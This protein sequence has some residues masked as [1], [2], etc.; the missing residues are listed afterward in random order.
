[1][2]K[3]KRN[4]NTGKDLAMYI[5]KTHLSFYKKRC[6]ILCVLILSFNIT[7]IKKVF[8][9]IYQLIVVGDFI[10]QAVKGD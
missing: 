8:R 7:F 5:R 3:F 9:S 1:M 6:V 4:V 10:T 2:M